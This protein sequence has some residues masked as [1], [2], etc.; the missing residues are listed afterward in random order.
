MLMGVVL[1]VTTASLNTVLKQQ[2]YM[3][4]Y[5]KIPVAKPVS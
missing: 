3:L 5:S 4:F 1:Q 2:A